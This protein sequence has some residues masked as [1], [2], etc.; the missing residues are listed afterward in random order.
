M[1]KQITVLE[2]SN[3]I[4]MPCEVFGSD[5]RTVARPAPIDA[6]TPDSVTF[7]SKDI[8]DAGQ[9]ISETA[10]GVVLCTPEAA[11][12]MD[13]TG[14]RTLLLVSNPRLAFIRVMNRFFAPPRPVGIHPTAVIHAEAKIG[15]DVYVG[16]FT[17]IGKAEIGDGTVVDGHAHIYDNVR[18]GRNCT[19]Q[20]GAIVGARGFGLER[21][22]DGLFE[23]MEHVGGV[24]I[25]DNVLVSSAVVIARGTMGDTVIGGGTKIDALTEIS[26]NAIIG[27]DC[28]VCASVVIA[29]SVTIGERAWISFCASVRNGASVGREATVGMGAVVTR[30]V[31]PGATVYGVP[32]RETQGSAMNAG[33]RTRALRRTEHDGGDWR[34]TYPDRSEAFTPGHAATRGIR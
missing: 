18:I 26:H 33:N 4:G 7:Y 16:P 25:G 13:G 22:E 2:L 32:A 11:A 8:E 27:R 9:H 20:A 28:G 6:A 24:V 3:A 15:K 23:E 10:A 19:I 30:D 5:D 31:P 17:Y 1:D 34:N 14:E 21:N 12:T 29:G